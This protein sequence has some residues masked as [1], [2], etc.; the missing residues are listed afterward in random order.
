MLAINSMLLTQDTDVHLL[1]MLRKLIY[2]LN[3]RA[4]NMLNASVH[5]YSTN[6]FSSSFL[7][8]IFSFGLP[9][10]TFSAINIKVRLVYILSAFFYVCT[11]RLVQF[12]IRT[13]RY[14][15]YT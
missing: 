7:C 8:G 11:V 1:T 4:W 15:T 2:T 14:K 5:I 13:N 6:L 9:T 3:A 10:F 12:V